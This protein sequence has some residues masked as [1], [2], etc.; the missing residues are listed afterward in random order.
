VPTAPPTRLPAAIAAA[1]GQRTG[2]RTAKITVVTT[3]AVPTITFFDALSSCSVA[4]ET[5]PTSA[6][7]RTPEAAPK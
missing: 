4:A 7:K 3:F 6:R 2:A 5:S 1:I